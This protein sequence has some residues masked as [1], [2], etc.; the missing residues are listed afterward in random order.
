MGQWAAILSLQFRSAHSIV[1]L[2]KNCCNIVFVLLDKLT[3]YN[4]LFFMFT[5]SVQKLV[6]KGERRR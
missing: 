5:D 3:E 6:N 1:Q 2:C 4:S